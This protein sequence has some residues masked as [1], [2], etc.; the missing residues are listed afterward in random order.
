MRFLRIKF[1]KYFT[2]V[3]LIMCLSLVFSFVWLEK[4]SQDVFYDGPIMFTNKK[5]TLQRSQTAQYLTDPQLNPVLRTFS[6]DKLFQ[7]DNTEINRV[8]DYL[9]NV[10]YFKHRKGDEL[11]VLSL[12]CEEYK[13]SRGFFAAPVTKLEQDFP[14]AYNILFHRNIEQFERLLRAIYRPQNQYCIHVDMKTPDDVLETMTLLT[15]CFDN[16]FIASKLEYIIYASYTRLVADINCMKD[17]IERNFEWK[18]LINMAASEF[19]IMT[20]LQTVQILNEF[21]GANDIHEVFITMDSQRFKQKHFTYIDIKSKSGYIIHTKRAKERPPY[22]LKI[23][24]GNAY[25]VFSRAFVVFVL[26]D[27]RARALLAWSTDTLTPDEHYWATLNN[28]YSN[29]FLE[30]P[31][32]FKGDPDKKPFFGRYIGWNTTKLLSRC[33][34]KHYVHNVCVFSALDLPALKDR[35]E[36]IANKFDIEYDPIAY[37]CMEEWIHN[38]TLNQEGIS[39]TKRYKKLAI[40]S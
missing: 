33:K 4:S 37:M 19:P 20:N 24:K 27:E 39:A 9:R 17:H 7:G 38:K 18:Y 40:T 25:N 8:S 22:G 14:I 21:N 16:V 1:V 32:G 35:Y 31:G 28:L 10:R 36:L 13:K 5:Q 34:E 12:N 15:D 3:S 23:T 26:E 6:C 11:R 30:T 2:Y 29:P